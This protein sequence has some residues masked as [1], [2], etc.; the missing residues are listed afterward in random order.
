MK[1]LIISILKTFIIKGAK[2]HSTESLIKELELS[3]TQILSRISNSADIDKNINLI[4]HIIGIEK[5]GQNRLKMLLGS[6]FKID[7]YDSYQPNKTNILTLAQKFESTRKETLDLAH[8]IKEIKTSK[9]SP[10]NDFGDLNA[11]EW[12]FYLNS[13]AQRESQRLKQ[14]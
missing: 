3:K 8:K 11:T 7:E 2:K 14:K 10:H 1:K 12:L 4:R 6:N 13:H 5:W 9:T